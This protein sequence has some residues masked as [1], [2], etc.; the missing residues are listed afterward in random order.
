MRPTRLRKPA[1]IAIV[2]T[3]FWL[4]LAGSAFGFPGFHDDTTGD[5][6]LGNSDPFCSSG[7]GTSC[8]V[9]T[10]CGSSGSVS[11]TS[12]NN[13]CSRNNVSVTCDGTTTYC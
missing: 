5:D 10:N 9:T 2:L 8:T 1:L 13:N 4:T 11:C 6:C 7:G 12:E 3:G